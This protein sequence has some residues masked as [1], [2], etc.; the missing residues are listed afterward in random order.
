MSFYFRMLLLL[1]ALTMVGPL[2]IDAYLPAVR[3]I[4][5]DLGTTDVLM[6]QTLSLFLY[7]T[8]EGSAVAH[9]L[10]LDGNTFR[11]SPSVDRQ[12]WVGGGELGALLAIVPQRVAQHREGGRRG[13]GAHQGQRVGG[14]LPA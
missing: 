6:Q 3:S 5:A 8:A 9:N 7:A 10:F 2:A 1:S 12:P 14:V 13:A 11:D 4:R